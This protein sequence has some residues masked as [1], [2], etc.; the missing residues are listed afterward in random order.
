[1]NRIAI[2][3]LGMHRSGT[4]ALTWLIGR[5]GATLPADAIAPTP[6]NPRGY[7]ESTGLV[8]ADDQLLRVARSSWFDP[9]P[10]DFSRLSPNA[11]ASRRRHIREALE[12]AFGTAPLFVVKDPRQCRFVPV[13]Q[14]VL[15][16]MHV[17]PRAV[18]MLRNMVDIAASI[19]SRDGT[20]PA[21]AHLLCLRH[22][23]DAEQGSRAMQRVVV[24]YDAMLA[25]WRDTAR[26]LAPLLGRDTDVFETGEAAEIDRF[27]DPSLRHHQHPRAALEEPLAGIIVEVEDG[28]RGLITS[29]DASARDRLDRAY[30][31]LEALPW[32]EGDVVHDELRHRR[33]ASKAIEDATPPAEPTQKAKATVTNPP[34]PP[35]HDPSGD[36][37]LIRNSGL[38]DADWYRARYADVP[39]DMDAVDHYLTIGAA[40]GRNPSPLFDTGYYARQMARR[41]AG[42]SGNTL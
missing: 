22:M 12:H 15:G 21:Y 36:A 13:V 10:L 30:A 3:V 34:P 24:D 7:W 42:Q 17:E 18:L 32:L 27:I 8:A 35:A 38:F 33:M 31:R 39:A 41:L 1:M 6:E 4:S 25:D 28:L 2:L 19:A 5:L 9:R 11:L 26:R 16:E 37:A 20:T 23:I 14:H 40:E 29:D